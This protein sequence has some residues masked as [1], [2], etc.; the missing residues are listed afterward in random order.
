MSFP[1][2]N[3]KELEGRPSNAGVSPSSAS[4]TSNG[5]GE[6]G[7]ACGVQGPAKPTTY[8]RDLAM[9]VVVVL[10]LGGLAWLAYHVPR[11]M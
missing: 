3:P 10:A 1:L 8:L 4:A 9:I 2:F 7:A 5:K 6:R 11:W